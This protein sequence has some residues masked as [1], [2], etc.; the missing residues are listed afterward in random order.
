MASSST[1]VKNRIN[2]KLFNSL[3]RY[4]RQIRV[5]KVNTVNDRYGK[6]DVVI[7]ML[8]PYVVTLN[9][10]KYA[11][12]YDE[13]GSYSNATMILL[14]SADLALT[15]NDKIY[16]DD[17]EYKVINIDVPVMSSDELIYRSFIEEV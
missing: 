4:N 6:R 10:K 13:T 15:S 12:K 14:S 1:V 3:K 11:K 8:T 9:Y 5:E 7:E 2:A 17:I 16:I